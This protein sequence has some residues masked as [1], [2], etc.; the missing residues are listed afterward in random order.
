MR[1]KQGLTYSILGDGNHN[2][3][4]E[5]GNKPCIILRINN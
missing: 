5:K 2:F 1:Q 4:D 3:N